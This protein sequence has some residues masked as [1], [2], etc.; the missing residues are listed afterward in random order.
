[1]RTKEV[2][3]RFRYSIEGNCTVHPCAGLW[4]MMNAG[5][6]QVNALH[7]TA[8]RNFLVVA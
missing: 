1:M 7:T 3:F 5:P 4:G 6:E 2:G 8:F